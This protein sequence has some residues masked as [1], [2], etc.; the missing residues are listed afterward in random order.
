MEKT[1]IDEFEKQIENV[2]NAP[3][4]MTNEILSKLTEPAKSLIEQGKQIHDTIINPLRDKLNRVMFSTKHETLIEAMVADLIDI[5]PG[6]GDITEAERLA[7][8]KRIGDKDAVVAHG[9]DTVFGE[10]A[11][12]IPVVGELIDSFL[13]ALLPANT[14]LYLKRRGIIEW[15]PPNPPLPKLKW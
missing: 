7:E 15:K 9:I 14:L 10:M 2:L 11:D 12:M 4:I 5:L 8:A 6:V 13:D 3:L 1:N